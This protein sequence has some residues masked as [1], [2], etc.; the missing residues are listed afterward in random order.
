MQ[1]RVAATTCLLLLL[2]SAT[3]S[4]ADA[5]PFFGAWNVD[6]T[7]LPIP[8]PPASVTITWADAGGGRVKMSVDILDRKGVATHAEST[9][10]LDGTATRAEGS[11]DVDIV[12]MT[13]PSERVLVMGAGMRGNPSNTRIFAISADGRHMSETIVSHA[14]GG[15][16]TTRV[17]QWTRK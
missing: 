13:M 15:I 17:N 11:L 4:G 6:V 3:T 9:F 1:H 10:P 8:E 7:R 2:F 12:S 5:R 14:P 16:P